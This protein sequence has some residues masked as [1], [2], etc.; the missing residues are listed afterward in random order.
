[1]PW[2]GNPIKVTGNK[3]YSLKKIV[4]NKTKYY[5]FIIIKL[6]FT[7][8]ILL[9]CIDIGLDDLTDTV[10]TLEAIQDNAMQYVIPIENLSAKPGDQSEVV[11]SWEHHSG[12]NLAYEL[13]YL[14][15]PITEENWDQTSIAY[16]NFNELES[17]KV[18]DTYQMTY[19]WHEVPQ[20]EKV[21]AV[22]RQ[23]I[24]GLGEVNEVFNL[25]GIDIAEDNMQISLSSIQAS[26]SI[27]FIDTGFRPDPDGY[28]FENFI[29]AK[30]NIKQQEY[31]H[32]LQ[33]VYGDDDVCVLV[34]HGNCEL[35]ESA[36]EYV[37][38]LYKS[39]QCSGFSTSSVLFYLD[40]E[41]QS[42]YEKKGLFNSTSVAETIQI[43]QNSKI[44]NL[45][46]SY[47][48]LQIQPEI[49]EQKQNSK[50]QN[51]D[52][53]LLNLSNMLSDDKR[54]PNISLFHQDS[55]D[56]KCPSHSVLPYFY[57]ED[58][59]VIV[60]VW[61]YDNN[62]PKDD[63]RLINLNKSNGKWN[64]SFFPGQKWSG[65]VTTDTGASCEDIAIHD[66]GSYKSIHD[67]AYF[68]QAPWVIEEETII[69]DSAGFSVSNKSGATFSY[70]ESGNFVN[71]IPGAIYGVMNEAGVVA[72]VLPKGEYG[73]DFMDNTS[74]ESS[75]MA[76]GSNQL[77]SVDN[78][79]AGD[80]FQFAKNEI[81]F[82]AGHESTSPDIK[83][84]H[85]EDNRSSSL[86]ISPEASNGDGITISYDPQT[87]EYQIKSEDTISYD[88]EIEGVTQ[89][90]ETHF[91]S[92]EFVHQKG[93]TESINISELSEG[94]KNLHIR[95][96]QDQDGDE[97]ETVIL[98]NDYNHA[99]GNK[100]QRVFICIGTA[101]I[102]FI[103]FFVIIKSRK[104]KKSSEA[105][106]YY[107]Y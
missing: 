48:A 61:V 67:G 16:I 42:N 91:D 11:L 107:D 26:N 34:D 36:E 24:K 35:K 70:D 31:F 102:V 37:S 83:I 10:T 78:A 19:H 44:N 88:L 73:I 13:H 3:S 1:M 62:H 58:D 12:V 94:N 30:K 15:T 6:L 7:S 85:D 49:L 22:I 90:G 97:D 25:L 80:H 98:N 17:Q 93:D 96:D 64:Y 74:N 51:T 86:L 77:I 45:I 27:S 39:G 41:D 4:K 76:M 14:N 9:S 101:I 103:L 72:I 8:L 5:L 95:I 87:L 47:Q 53:Y 81:S 59:T 63:S 40:R 56:K 68:G 69:V 65:L 82:I 23:S 54:Y 2:R 33:N 20:R 75:F 66:I 106:D 21:W 100:S 79:K 43:N 60:K 57:T 29:P 104:K 32:M 105:D 28:E 89:D 71:Q 38:V 46:M 52:E 18:G 55:T 92:Q 99:N 84:I 50:N